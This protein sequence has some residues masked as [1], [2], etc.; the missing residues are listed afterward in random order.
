MKNANKRV[1]SIK[2]KGRGVFKEKKSVV[3]YT[4]QLTSN[5][6]CRE[7]KKTEKK[8]GIRAYSNPFEFFK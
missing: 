4:I 2:K 1:T 3:S 6:F 7:G 8:A 5:G